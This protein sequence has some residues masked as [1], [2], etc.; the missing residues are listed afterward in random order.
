MFPSLLP[1]H[2]QVRG[3]N[4]ENSKDI[5]AVFFLSLPFP[6]LTEKTMK[7]VLK[8]D[9]LPSSPRTPLNVSAGRWRE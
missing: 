6:P 4:A 3:D 1:W 5:F 8:D 7:E 9:S 2:P